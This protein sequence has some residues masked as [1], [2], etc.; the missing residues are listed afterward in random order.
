VGGARRGHHPA[1]RLDP[2]PTSIDDA[3]A[4]GNHVRTA[5]AHA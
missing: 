4:L 2:T 1:G 3:I 5:L